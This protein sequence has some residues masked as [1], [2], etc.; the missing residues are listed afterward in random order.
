MSDFAE[1]KLL[2]IDVDGTMTDG[3][4]YYDASGNEIK[5]LILK[6]Q[7]EYLPLVVRG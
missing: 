4:I 7:P 1:I 3:G 5:N 2:V 6:M